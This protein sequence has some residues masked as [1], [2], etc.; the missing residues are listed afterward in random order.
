MDEAIAEATADVPLSATVAVDEEGGPVQRLRYSKG[1]LLLAAEMAEGTPEEAPPR[2]PNTPPAWPSWGHYHE[3]RPGG[4]PGERGGSGRPY[5]LADP[6]EVGRYASAVVAAMG[7]SGITPVVKHWPG[8]G[9]AQEDPHESLP[10]LADLQQLRGEDMAAFDAVMESTPV[11][12]MVAH[13]EVPGLTAPGAGIAQHR[14]DHRRTA[15]TR[16]VRRRRDHRL[17]RDGCDREPAVAVRGGGEGP[18]RGADIALLSG[19]DV[20]ADTHARVTSGDRGRE[21]SLS[22]NRSSSP[23]GVLAP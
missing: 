19:S 20:V 21:P 17:A 5:L 14:G 12:V 6:E 7:S 8:I 11:A 13:A 18:S 15:G 23:R 9:G 22:R 1:R 10:V 2:W 4:R 3:L 16:G